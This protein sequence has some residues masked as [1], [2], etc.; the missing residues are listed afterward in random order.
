MLDSS[1]SVIST[2]GRPGCE[3]CDLKYAARPVAKASHAWLIEEAI[4]LP[5]GLGHDWIDSQT[6]KKVIPTIPEAVSAIKL[7]AIRV[8]GG[9]AASSDKTSNHLAGAVLHAFQAFPIRKDG[10]LSKGKMQCVREF[11]DPCKLPQCGVNRTATPKST[12]VTK[13]VSCTERT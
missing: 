11:A 5:H 9:N 12:Q 8:R 3:A 2:S 4:S 6:T 7:T 10:E 1:R 13:A